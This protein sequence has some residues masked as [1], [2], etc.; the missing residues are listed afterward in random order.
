MT[1]EI[2]I[3]YQQIKNQKS[4]IFNQ[5][6]LNLKFKLIILIKIFD[7]QFLMNEPNDFGNFYLS[8]PNQNR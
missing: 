2:F 6:S 7:Y 8:S 3:H 1:S 4:L 5:K